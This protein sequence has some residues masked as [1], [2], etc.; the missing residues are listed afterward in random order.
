M[1]GLFRIKA[2][3]RLWS[4]SLAWMSLGHIKIS[5]WSWTSP[6]LN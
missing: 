4:I 5:R 2:L 6:G 1:A 3:A